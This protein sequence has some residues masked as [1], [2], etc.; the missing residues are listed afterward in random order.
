MSTKT[1]GTI[2]A[3][4]TFVLLIVIAVLSVFMQMI[5]LNGASEN[6]GFTALVISIIAQSIGLLLSV[7]IV[8]VL[9]KLFIEK[10]SWNN[11][12]AIIAAI[13]AGTTF[14][15]IVALIATVVSIPLAGIK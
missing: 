15:G 12:L 8:R 14:G 10:F 2:A 13:L 3:L 4:T 7:I 9:T 11:I 1:S 5:V 6:K